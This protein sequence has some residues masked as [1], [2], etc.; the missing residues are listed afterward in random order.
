M[1]IFSFQFLWSDFSV[2][3][4]HIFHYLKIIFPTMGAEIVCAVLEWKKNTKNIYHFKRVWKE[5]EKNI[6]IKWS[7][8]LFSA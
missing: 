4:C 6:I 3:R 8:V 1:T 5:R 7:R 2:S